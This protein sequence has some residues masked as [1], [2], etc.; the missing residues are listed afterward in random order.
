M[1]PQVRISVSVVVPV[2]NIASVLSRSLESLI[3]QDFP[4]FE[5]IIIDNHST[6]NS[7]EV[8]KYFC[9]KHQRIPIRIIRRRHTYS[10]SESYNL[11]ARLAK[12]DCVVMMHSDG[13]LPSRHELGRLIAP[14][15]RDQDIIATAPDIFH[16]YEVWR[17]Y[18]FWQKC[19]FAP[20]VGTVR[21]SGNGKFD[22][23]RR[24][25]F[26]A[27]GGY[28]QINFASDVGSEDADMYRRLEKIGRVVGSS[29][30]VIHDHP[31][32]LKYSLFDWMRRRKFLAVSYGRHLQI[33]IRDHRWHT[34]VF[35]LKPLLA[36]LP[37]FAFINPLSV[38][39]T[40]VFPFWY[41]RRMF[42]DKSTFM[43][44]RIVAIPFIVWY[45]LYAETY[46]MARSFFFLGNEAYNN[47]V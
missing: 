26:F 28:D 35:L 17:H 7:V 23:Y 10:I 42:L 34:F 41:M 18:P 3:K 31:V 44:I 37:V 32:E 6:D 5:I 45:L 14:L 27:V 8:A 46:W 24:S 25:A 36:I 38:V 21:G 13:V 47:V 19:L 43:D 4:I 16:P 29:A 1:N 39:P 20:M 2:Y 11:G 15:L 30:Q 33:H 9:M 12:G 22:A 40:V